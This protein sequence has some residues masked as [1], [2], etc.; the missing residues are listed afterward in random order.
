[1]WEDSTLFIC[2]AGIAEATNMR[3]EG[4]NYGRM[5]YRLTKT[6]W[7]VFNWRNNLTRNLHM[8]V[9]PGMRWVCL[10]LRYDAP[11]LQIRLLA[12]IIIYDCLA[13]G[14]PRVTIGY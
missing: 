2:P 10:A 5:T 8:C 6:S 1:M 14:V 11:T 4:E 3:H 13:F 7:H 12:I 9:F